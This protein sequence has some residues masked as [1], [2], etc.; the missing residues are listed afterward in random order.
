[1]KRYSFLDTVMIV[2]GVEI[3]GWDEGDDVITITRL[4]DSISHKVGAAGEMMISVSGDKS[5][6]FKFKLQQTSSS[7][8]M[9]SAMLALQEAAGSDFVATNCLFQDT[10]RQ[11]LAIGTVGYI[12]KPADM[13]RGKQGQTQEWEII[14]E[15]LDLLFGDV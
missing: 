6:S 3:V 7:N 2:N 9:L 15:R 8:A 11:D 5:G 4:N 14:T 12:K 10:Y 13:T 1:M